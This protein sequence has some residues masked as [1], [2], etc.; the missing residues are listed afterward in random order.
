MQ[1]ACA[2]SPVPAPYVPAA[3]AAMLLLPVQKFPVV[4]VAQ[5]PMADCEVAVDHVPATQAVMAEPPLHQLPAGH[6][7]HTPLLV[8]ALPLK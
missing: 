3:H 2:V 4:H 7:T 1:P 8:P 6:V 5:V